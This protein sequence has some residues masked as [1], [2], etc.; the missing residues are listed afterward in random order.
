MMLPAAK[1]FANPCLPAFWTTSYDAW[2]YLFTLLAVLLMQQI[3]WQI[4]ASIGGFGFLRCTC[5]LSMAEAEKTV[6]AASLSQV[7]FRL[8]LWLLCSVAICVVNEQDPQ[9]CCRPRFTSGPSL[10]A[11]GSPAVAPAAAA[12]P[13]E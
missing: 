9:F 10:A 7:R 12:V 5:N 11:A 3:D 4:K 8:L 1:S 13:P 2:A 6:A